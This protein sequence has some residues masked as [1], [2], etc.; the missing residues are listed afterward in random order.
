MKLALHAGM[1]CAGLVGI[2]AARCGDWRGWLEA[3]GVMGWCATALIVGYDWG[4]SERFCP[5]EEDPGM[6][7]PQPYPQEDLCRMKRPQMR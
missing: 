2:W 1:W 3:V 5:P 7:L 6:T 4:R